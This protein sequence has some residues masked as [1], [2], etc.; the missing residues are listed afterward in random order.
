MKITRIKITTIFLIASIMFAGFLSRSF[1]ENTIE[2]E[3]VSTENNKTEEITTDIS[4]INPSKNGYIVYLEDD[5]LYV[6]TPNGEAVYKENDIKNSNFTENDLTKLR[7][8]GIEVSGFTELIE[9]LNYI[10]S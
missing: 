3:V 8:S 5:T 1:V 4:E 7:K 10:K 9:L 6:Y 2:Y